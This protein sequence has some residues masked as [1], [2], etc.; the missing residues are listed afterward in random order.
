MKSY[1]REDL[2]AGTGRDGNPALVAVHGKVYDVSASKRWINGKH[3]NRHQA[4]RDLSSDIKASPHG[5]QVLERFEPVG[6]Y[7]APPK[8]PVRGF[9]GRFDEWLKLHPLFRRHPHP[10]I[11]HVPVGIVVAVP[12]FELIALLTG[13][14]RTE[15]AS[16]CCMIMVLVS[17]PAAMVSGYFT[18]WIN[19]DCAAGSIVKWK[20]GL[21][22]TALGCAGLSVLA[23]MLVS[24]PLN[25]GDPLVLILV[26]CL[27]ATAA[28]IC[29]IGFLGGKLTFPYE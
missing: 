8:T 29:A 28:M 14:S 9:K 3:M 25:V 16:F 19:Y 17:M 12:V 2:S 23:R 27:A 20:I 15:W 1:S 21:A 13:S 4:G 10:A 6:T 26:A 5:T 22:F 7:Q 18:W 24:D 11:V